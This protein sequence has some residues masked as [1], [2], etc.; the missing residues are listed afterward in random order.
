[1]KKEPNNQNSQNIEIKFQTEHKINRVHRL[2]PTNLANIPEE[3]KSNDNLNMHYKTPSNKKNKK[4]INEELFKEKVEKELIKRKNINIEFIKLFSQMRA[5]EN[6]PINNEDKKNMFYYIINRTWFH[7]F[8]SYCAKTN[9]KY[10]NLNEDYPGPIN[11]QHLILKEENCLK[12]NSENRIIINPKY[13]DNCTCISQEI[14][15]FLINHCGGGPEIKLYPYKSNL[16]YDLNEINTIRRGAHINLIFLPKKQIISNNNN[17]EPSN[18]MINPLNPFQCLDIKKILRNIDDNNIRTEKIYFDIS[19]NVKEL[20]N[21]INLILNQHRDKFTNTPII[22]GPSFNSEENSLVEN[23][24]YRLWLLILN[25]QA[26]IKEIID[27]IQEQITKYEDAD[28]LMN[29]TQINN[30]NSNI[31]MPYLL[32]DFLKYKIMDIFPNK[33]TNNFD[34][35]EFYNKIEDENTMPEMY[36]LI[37]ENPF[38]FYSPKKNYSIRKCNHCQYRD[39]VFPACQCQK[40]YYCSEE[41]KKLNFQSHI[42]SCKIGLY[43]FLSLKNENLYKTILGRKEYFEKNK[44]DKEKFPILGLTNLGNSCYMNSALQCIFATKELSNYF[45][46]NFSEKYINKN[47]ILGSGGLLTLGYINLLLNINN[48]TNNRYIS[49]EF[50][51]IVLGLCSSKFEGNEQEDAHEFI[52][53]LLDAFHEDINR[54]IEKPNNNEDDNIKYNI[55]EISFDEK[56]IIEW[57]NFLRRNQS[58]LIDLFYGQ[59]KS[60]V[61][62]PICHYHSINFNS[63]LSLELSI[64]QDK[65]YHLINIEFVDYSSESPIINFNVVLYNTENKI[66]FVRKKIANLLNIDLLSFELGIIHNNK[67]MKIFD[68]NDEIDSNIINIIAYRV[69]PEFFYS[70]KNLRY[71]EIINNERINGNENNEN[72]R[73]NNKHRIDFQNLEF[74]INKRKNEIIKF[75]ENEN[76]S[77][78]DDL[79]SMNLL[80]QNNIGLDNSIFQR[81]V[82]ENFTIKRGQSKNLSSDEIIYLEKSKSCED[83]YYQIFKKYII[84]IIANFESS[85]ERNKFINTYKQEE[86][87]A[88]IRKK[89]IQYFNDIN[90]TDML[91]SKLNLINNFPNIPFILFLKNEKYNIQ[92][93]LPVSN[94]IN[95]QDKLKIFYDSINFEKNKSNQTRQFNQVKKIN[96]EEN[97]ENKENKDND[98]YPQFDAFIDNILKENNLDINNN[99]ENNSKKKGLKGGNNNEKNS[100]EDSESQNEESE[101]SENNENQYDENNFM[102]NNENYS[103]KE[104]NLDDGSIETKTLSSQSSITNSNIMTAFKDMDE[105]DIMKLKDDN[106]DRLIIMWNTKFLKELNRFSN[107]N[108]YDICEKIYEKSTNQEIKLEKLFSEFSKE[109]K[110]DRDNLYKCEKC[111]EESEANKK[112]EIYHVPKVLIIHLKRFNNNKKINTFIDFPLRDLDINEFIKSNDRVSK[113]DLFGVINHYGSM[114]YGHYTSYCLNYHDDTWYEYNDRIVNKIPKEKE[115]DTIV[116]KNAYILFYRC[117]DNDLI[118]WDIIYNKKYENINENNLKQ[119][120]SDFV[121]K[122]N[123][124]KNLILENMNN[125]QKQNDEIDIDKNEIIPAINIEEEKNEIEDDNFSFKEGMNNKSISNITNN[126]EIDDGGDAVNETPKFRNRVEKIELGNNLLNFDLDKDINNIENDINEIKEIKKEECKSEIKTTGIFN[127]ITITKNNTFRIKTFYKPRKKVNTEPEKKEIKKEKIN[128]PQSNNNKNT[129]ENELLKYNIFNQ[130]RNFFK[131]NKNKGKSKKGI[132]SV[133]NQELSL[134]ILKEIC[135]NKSNK[136]PRSKKLY[137]DILPEIKEQEQIEPKK[138]QLNNIKEKENINTSEINLQD[139]VYN[140]FSNCY[141]K[142]RKFDNN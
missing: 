75:N 35:T 70:E 118:N 96:K 38:H 95:Y 50:F 139:Y 90:N 73:I 87:E 127:G 4:E 108:L 93:M 56:S 11:N 105:D 92:E 44:I 42:I 41:C 1:M 46:Y 18:N 77:I 85:K 51:K 37:E 39:Y 133:K 23:I 136:V 15:N 126:N 28:F 36:I 19:K 49:P 47:N 129:N 72:I 117:Q 109:E 121:L 68:L 101:N 53:Y 137:D 29:F 59:L 102:E 64:N 76:R 62:C 83:I 66:Y 34:N 14:W 61:I 40:V 43:N 141:M 86:N 25:N 99:N 12:L 91:P 116:N 113:Y 94:D 122:E 89:F 45:L 130:S 6:S 8:K 103:S 30:N 69:N 54:V 74:N 107:I 112:I 104:L 100:E 58:V 134:F 20:I 52:N 106:L 22:F 119:F 31:I 26:D 32:T 124:K 115:N 27:S 88:I 131:L 67:I 123:P 111:K 7:Q 79:F 138:E 78:N 24:N 55:N 2:S 120:G 125:I 98:S 9:L 128:D 84:N 114:E 17:K 16:P 82:I 63:F 71:N 65:N 81:I 80:Y 60:S 140:P 57:N 5:R 48:T 33:Y 110:L 13:S 10:S 21:Y 97:K 3:E 135:D 132:K 142:L